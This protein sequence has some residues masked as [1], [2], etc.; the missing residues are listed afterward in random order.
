MQTV[1]KT[2]EICCQWLFCGYSEYEHCVSLQIH[3]LKTPP[4][5]ADEK[6]F[7][8]RNVRKHVCLMSRTQ[9]WHASIVL[10]Q[11]EPTLYPPRFLWKGHRDSSI[12]V[13]DKY[14]RKSVRQ[15]KLHH[16]TAEFFKK[17][18]FSSLFPCG[19]WEYA[20]KSLTWSCRNTNNVTSEAYCSSHPAVTT[21]HFT[22]VFM[23]AHGSVIT[24]EL[25]PPKLELQTFHAVNSFPRWT[26]YYVECRICITRVIPLSLCVPQLLKTIIPFCRSLINQGT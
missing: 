12:K 3:S 4:H 14:T 11:S 16:N 7:E 13:R 6:S 15:A 25:N 19:T 18:T 9:S 26:D 21:L 20:A 1:E 23:I 2:T 8:L 24:S 10:W 5:Y 22:A 17:N